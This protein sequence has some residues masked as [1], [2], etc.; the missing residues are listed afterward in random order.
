ML[1]PDSLDRPTRCER[2]GASSVGKSQ[3]VAYSG[4]RRRRSAI[5]VAPVRDGHDLDDENLI[6]NS[7]DHAV[8]AAPGGVQRKE[9]FLQLLADA[10]RVVAQRSHDERPRSSGNLL[11]QLLGERALG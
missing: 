10:L 2:D 8:F 1:I 5:G 11:G 3:T 6:Q 9:R 7:V 4:L